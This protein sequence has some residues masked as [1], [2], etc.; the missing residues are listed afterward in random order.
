VDFFTLLLLKPGSF[1]WAQSFLQ[2]PAW[3]ALN[4]HF[5]GNP[6]TFSLPNSPP[7][8][9]IFDYSC[10]DPP[11]PICLQLLEEDAKNDVLDSPIDHMA[12]ITS[13]S[14][15]QELQENSVAVTPPPLAPPASAPRAK[16][17]KYWYPLSYNYKHHFNKKNK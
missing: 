2:S 9:L 7:S 13:L 3:A 12:S 16:Q 5:Y 8:V 1:E 4:Q 17:G 10:S 6:F 14:S 11:T 15:T